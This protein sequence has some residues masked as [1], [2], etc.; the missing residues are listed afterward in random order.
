MCSVLCNG[1]QREDATLIILF[2]RR[3]LTAL[4]RLLAI[5]FLVRCFSADPHCWDKDTLSGLCS[6]RGAAAK[7]AR[8]C[9][10]HEE[11]EVS[12]AE[13]AHGGG[14]ETFRSTMLR[15]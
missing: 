12:L 11:E 5:I 2:P 15:F 13:G 10:G 6:F 9:L 3:L 8:A 1:V 7:A 14:F 4:S